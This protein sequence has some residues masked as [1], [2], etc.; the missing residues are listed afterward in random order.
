MGQQGG[1]FLGRNTNQQ[2][3]LGGN[4]QGQNQGMNQGRMGANGMANLLGNTN[5]GGNRG[6][7]NLMNSQMGNFGGSNTNQAP[8]I[9]PRQRVAFD[10]PAPKSEA[11]QTSLQGQITKVSI[12][13]PRLSNVMV[14]TNA[15]GEVVIRGAV[16]SEADAKLAENLVRLEPGV[17]S[18]RNE[19]TFIPTEPKAD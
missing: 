8:V 11:L 5:R 18:V 15:G 16:K 19:L 4:N 2:Q 9:R 1:G 3:F 13:N 10:Y 7:M 6:G 12:K 17:R 14:T